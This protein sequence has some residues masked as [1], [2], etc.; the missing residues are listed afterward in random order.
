MISWNIYEN[1]FISIYKETFLGFYA[2]TSFYEHF[3]RDSK[4]YQIYLF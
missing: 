3:Q 2:N 1:M 4:N